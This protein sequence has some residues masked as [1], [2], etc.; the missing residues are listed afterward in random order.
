MVSMKDLLGL[1]IINEI[2]AL[3]FLLSLIGGEMNPFFENG[4]PT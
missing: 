2:A 1:L 4:V 3:F